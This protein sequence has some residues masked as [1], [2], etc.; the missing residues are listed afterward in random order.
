MGGRSAWICSLISSSLL[1]I[2]ETAE[3]AVDHLPRLKSTDSLVISSLIG[4]LATDIFLP[5]Y[6]PWWPG[7]LLERKCCRSN[8]Q[9]RIGRLWATVFFI[10]FPSRDVRRVNLH[11][12]HGGWEH[13]LASYMEGADSPFPPDNVPFDLSDSSNRQVARWRGNELI[14]FPCKLFN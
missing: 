6:F 1:D 8:S 9:R 2:G 10:L 3:K 13:V 14:D 5:P 4:S 7:L 12:Q 11:I